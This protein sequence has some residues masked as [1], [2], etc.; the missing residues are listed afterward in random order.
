MVTS[1]YTDWFDCLYY[2]IL[3]KY[4]DT[5]EAARFIEKLNTLFNFSEGQN[6]LELG[7][8]DGERAKLLRNFGLKVTGID[9][10]V[11]N[12]V[13]ARKKNINGA[14]FL[15]HDMRLKFPFVKQDYVFNFFSSFGY[16]K[17]FIEHEIVLYNISDALKDGGYLMIDYINAESLMNNPYFTEQIVISDYIFDISIQIKESEILKI[18]KIHG[19]GIAKSYHEKVSI[20]Y[21]LEM[22]QMLHAAGMEIVEVYSDYQLK[23]FI[24]EVS[25]RLIIVA[26]KI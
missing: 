1:W 16:Y 22:E 15:E 3:Y 25:P 23:E 6:I 9:V 7:C 17:T 24:P 26:K 21:L 13:A 19:K 10:S 2:P 12:I 8:G 11:D 5:V 18:I 20:I 4:R 14:T